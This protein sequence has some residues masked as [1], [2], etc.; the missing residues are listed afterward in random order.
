M[1]TYIYSTNFNLTNP[2]NDFDAAASYLTDDDMTEYLVSHI[3]YEKSAANAAGLS[4]DDIENIQWIL[5]SDQD[6]KIVLTTN[7]ELSKEALNLISAWVSGQCSDGLGEGFEQQEF[8]ELT[9]EDDPDYYETA[10]FDWQTNDYKFKLDSVRESKSNLVDSIVDRLIE[11]ASVTNLIADAIHVDAAS[12]ED[13][14]IL[15][16][17]TQ[18]APLRVDTP[19]GE[20]YLWLEDDDILGSTEKPGRINDAR[21]IKNFTASG[22]VDLDDVVLYVRKYF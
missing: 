13:A 4:G 21:A 6:G 1:S 19:R 9:D 7:K 16:K 20:Y 14:K 17:P 15:V 3:D 8:A 22:F 12:P 5:N 10:S 2:V 18:D 11:G